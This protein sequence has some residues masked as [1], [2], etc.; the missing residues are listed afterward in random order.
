MARR[1]TTSSYVEGIFGFLL[2]FLTVGGISSRVNIILGMVIAA[3]LTRC[4]LALS[5]LKCI[6]CL[7]KASSFEIT[8]TPPLLDAPTYSLATLGSDGSTG[9][10]ILTYASPVGVRPDRVWTL[11]LFKGT[12]AHDNFSRSGKGVLQLLRR[13][14]SKVVRLLGGTSGS[15]VD[16]EAQCANLGFPWV[17]L[18]DAGCEVGR[19]EGSPMVLPGCAYYIRLVLM[20]EL[21]D[22]GSHDVAICR[23]ESMLVDEGSSACKEYPGYL[24]TATLRDMGIISEQGRVVE[25]LQT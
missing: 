16:K 19:E 2:G 3:M 5:L 17:K 12:V 8:T 1:S 6:S 20:G 9:M 15:D 22:A 10:N 25:P 21:I 13:D 11:G 4:L 18:D 23:V 7:P 24:S 14:H